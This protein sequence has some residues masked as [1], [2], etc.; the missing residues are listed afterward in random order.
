MT[1]DSH[2]WTE[3]EAEDEEEAAGSSIVKL[4]QKLTPKKQRKTQAG[5]STQAKP[6]IYEYDE[7]CTDQVTINL[8]RQTPIKSISV[9]ASKSVKET[10]VKLS[11][12]KKTELRTLLHNYIIQKE[13]PGQRGTWQIIGTASLRRSLL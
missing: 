12:M 8:G 5:T 13:H 6:L 4:A 1:F 7:E 9:S 2:H 11:K 10:P 3:Y